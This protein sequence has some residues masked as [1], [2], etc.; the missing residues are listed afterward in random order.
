MTNIRHGLNRV[1]FY[2]S[3]YLKINFD[4]IT[5]WLMLNM[6]SQLISFVLR[7]CTFVIKLI[8]MWKV[9]SRDFLKFIAVFTML[10]DHIGKIFFP[11]IIILQIVGRLAFPI[12]AF[13]IAEGFYFTRNKLKYFLT[14]LLFAVIAQIPYNFL[15][16]SLNILF[17]FLFSFLIL[18]LWEC[19]KKLEKIEKIILRGIT[20]IVFFLLIGIALLVRADYG[21]YGILLPFVFYVLRNHL[22]W[23]F[24]FFVILTILIVVESICVNFPAI[25]FVSFIQLFALF[26]ILPLSFYNDSLKSNK[27][28]KYLFYLFYPLHLV[29]LLVLKI[30]IF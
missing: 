10:V 11:D 8:Y 6:L 23:K 16:H 30:V 4:V 2:E 20:L 9:F 1:F 14:I 13:F 26:S 18:F 28:F 5:R 24:L 12:F 27:K 15:W 17:T 3:I 25:S 19:S 21:W 29:L 22:F 7:R